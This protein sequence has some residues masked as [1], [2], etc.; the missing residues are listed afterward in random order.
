MRELALHILDLVQ[1]SIEANSTRV[2]L[3]IT[4]DSQSDLLTIRI[5][6]DGRGMAQEIVKQVRDPFVTSRTTRRVGLGLA[7]IDMST[8][9]S[10][11]YLDIQSQVGQGTTVTAV[12]QYNHFDRPPLGDMA[13]TV[14]TI[15]V[16]NPGLEFS[17]SHTVNNK[18]FAVATRDLVEILGD[19]PLSHP[20]V[21]EWMNG[22]LT[23]GIAN[24]YGGASIEN[25]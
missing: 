22:Y 20:E 11:G 10:G 24:L 18:V 19:I 15:I 5:I 7:L 9:Q 13:A 12:Y 23:E 25:S 1:N 16:A 14:K 17:Y 21:L 2:E 4:E 3:Q 6:D 8:T